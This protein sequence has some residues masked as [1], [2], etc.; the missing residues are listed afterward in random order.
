MKHVLRRVCIAILCVW[1]VLA[2]VFVVLLM[3]P[4]ELTPFETRTAS[5][6]FY[7]VNGSLLRDVPTKNSTRARW[8]SL[9]EI[10]PFV[11]Q[12]MVALEDRRFYEH[13]GV[14]LK[15]VARALRDN[16]KAR[17]VVSGGSTITQQLVEIDSGKRSRTIW[18][19]AVEAMSALRLERSMS[20]SEILEQYLN[21]APFGYQQQG[22]ESAAQFYFGK[23]ALALTLAESAMLVG[24]PQAPSVQNPLANFKKAK[25]RQLRVLDAMVREGMVSEAEAE[26]AK[27]QNIILEKPK[28]P[29]E[30][31]HLT[32]YWLRTFNDQSPRVVHTN[33]DLPLQH[34]AEIAVRETVMSLQDKRVSEGAVIVLENGKVGLDAVRA[35]VGSPNYFEPRAGQVDMVISPRQPGSALKPFVY[36]L[37]LERGFKADSLL[38]DRPTLFKAEGGTFRPRNYDGTFHGLVTLRQSLACSYNIPALWLANRLKAD[39]VLQRLRDIGFSTLNQS[40]DFYGL[41]IALGNGE[42]TL[43]ELAKAYQVLAQG[44]IRK[45]AQGEERIM[46]E[47][48]AN[49][50]SDILSDPIARSPAFGRYGPTETDYPTAVKTGTSSDFNDHWTVGFTPR[51]TVAAWVGNFD[52]SPMDGHEGMRG[53]SILWRR[54]MDLVNAHRNEPFS[55]NGLVKKSG[56]FGDEW[57]TLG[58]LN[59]VEVSRRIGEKFEI[60]FPFDD[61]VLVFDADV[62][63]RYAKFKCKV[64]SIYDDV[65]FALDGEVLPGSGKERWCSPDTG[66]HVLEA[67]PRS[68]PSLKRSVHFKLEGKPW[69]H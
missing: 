24:V 44:G 34:E 15:A 58:P 60:L 28:I 10:S 65:E 39:S 21:R 37:A 20:K 25:A 49:L 29:F 45:T 22:I 5:T 63:K 11:P 17:R 3:C 9:D 51:F 16:L 50:L 33:I 42:V 46:P 7:D 52:G 8:R 41:G 64:E 36:G 56:E 62:P 27:Q 57:Y 67:W 47:N 2:L 55:H 59:G 30:T 61:D 13:F 31:P 66:S 54:V 26:L 40:V 35:W 12:A 53:A 32:N 4:F 6:L 14:D 68:E 18:S 1:A 43:F 38:P 69:K 23:S 19:K 48:V